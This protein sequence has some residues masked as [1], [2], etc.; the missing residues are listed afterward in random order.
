MSTLDSF[1]GRPRIPLGP[2]S[3][4]ASDLPPLDQQSQTVNRYAEFDGANHLAVGQSWKA[5][6][7][8]TPGAVFNDTLPLE[9]DLSAPL[10]PFA[11]RAAV[12]IGICGFAVVATLLFVAIIERMP[13]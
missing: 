2:R 9:G 11:K 6:V 8:H 5:P 13:L 10:G 1:T 7:R 4:G 3:W 12:L